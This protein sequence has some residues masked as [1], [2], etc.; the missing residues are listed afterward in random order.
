MGEVIC[1]GAVVP[2]AALCN[3]QWCRVCKAVL[4]EPQEY[5]QLALH[6][7]YYTDLDSRLN[8]SRPRP[9]PMV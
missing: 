6:V 1:Q 7:V 2:L 8:A 3:H 4:C 5:E 9:R